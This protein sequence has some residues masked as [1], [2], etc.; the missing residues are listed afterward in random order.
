MPYMVMLA[1]DLPPQEFTGTLRSVSPELGGHMRH[2]CLH[3]LL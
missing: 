3:W 1:R 2:L